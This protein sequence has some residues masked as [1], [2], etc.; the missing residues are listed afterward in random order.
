MAF[1]VFVKEKV[2][3]AIIEVGIGGLYDC[4]NV[5]KYRFLFPLNILYLL[6]FSNLSD[7][8]PKVVGISS[9]GLDHLSLLGDTV[10]K[11]AVQ[12]AGIM[13]PG[14]PAF[15]ASDQPG[16]TMRVLTEK[17]LEVQVCAC[18]HVI[19][20]KLILQFLTFST[21]RSVLFTSYL[22]STHISGSLTKQSWD[23]LA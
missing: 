13:K 11:I 1:Y 4:T 9:L 8:K 23:C 22:H 19:H 7:R 5:V 17:A 2:D 15:T 16:D 21:F 6:T 20:S 3:V 12:K 18:V 14:V 10:E